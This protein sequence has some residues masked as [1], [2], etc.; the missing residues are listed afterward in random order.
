ML[1]CGPA[2]SEL[3]ESTLENLIALECRVSKRGRDGSKDATEHSW[4]TVEVVDAASV[5][6]VDFLLEELAQVEEAH[7]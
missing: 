3:G 5:V 2:F 4:K 1:T 6:Q 7:S